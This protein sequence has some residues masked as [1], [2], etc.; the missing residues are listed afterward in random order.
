MDSSKHMVTQEGLIAFI[1]SQIR[2]NVYEHEKRSI[3][4]KIVDRVIGEMKKGG[5]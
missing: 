5:R 2:T 4:K 1:R 3:A